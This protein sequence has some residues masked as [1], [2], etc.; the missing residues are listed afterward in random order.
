MS[1]LTAAMASHDRGL[2]CAKCEVQSV[3]LA[4]PSIVSL[5]Y[6]DSI[7][8]AAWRTARVNAASEDAVDRLTC[9]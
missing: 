1:P 2:Q 4:L 3:R 5:A 9:Q 7:S 6:P 8:D